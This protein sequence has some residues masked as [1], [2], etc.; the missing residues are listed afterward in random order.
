MINPLNIVHTESS[1]GW[2]G[3]EVRIL[4][5]SRGLLERGHR[6]RI[7][8][9]EDA[10]ILP[11]ARE[12][13]IPCE[14]LPIRKKNFAG[15]TAAR[16]WLA[17]QRVEIVNTH[18]STDSWL[19]TLAAHSLG[20]KQ[21]PRIVRTRHLGAPV[22][23]NPASNWLYGR[24]CDHLVTCGSIMR[25]QLI[26]RNGVA[27]AHCTSIPTGI[28]TTRFSPGDCIS[29]RQDLGLPTDRKLVGIVAALRRE[30]GH[31][32]LCTAARLLERTDFDLLIVGDGL[33]RD[34]LRGWIAENELEQRVH[35]PGNQQ[36]VV[37]WLRAMDLFVLPSYGIEGV[38][39]G[40]MQAMSC[41]LPVIA[42]TVGSIPE[43]VEADKTGLL[44]PPQNPEELA[45]ALSRLL[46]DARLREQFGQAG[47]DKAVRQFGLEQMLD[48]MEQVFWFTR[49]TSGRIA[50]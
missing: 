27:P 18:S 40:I 49:E 1:R 28:D 12:A 32:V 50:A 30:K 16:R 31:Q 38:P 29:A 19:F 24:G 33:S 9:N 45:R 8:C 11:K 48:R 10:A 35:T 20:K 39:Q 5:E 43:A 25:E 41:G 17:E 36:D 34:L 42:T 13:G 2:G 21:R 23:C 14:A 47:R 44:I 3:Q 37:P 26:Q 46:D 22:P 7:L 6:V 4:A 15:L